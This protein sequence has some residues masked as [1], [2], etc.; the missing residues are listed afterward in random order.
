MP[1]AQRPLAGKPVSPNRGAPPIVV[2]P[3]WLIKALALCLVTALICAYAAACLLYY[4]GEWQFLLHPS[5]TVERTP[6]SVGLLYKDIRFDASETGQPRLTAWWLPADF[7]NQSDANFSAFTVLYLHDGSGSL[8]DTVPTLATLHRV[9]LNVFAIDYRG[10]G[11]S[12]S[13]AHPSDARMTQDAAAAFDYLT[14]VRHIPARNIVP[15]GVGLGASLAARLAHDHPDL[16]AVVLDNP[17]PDPLSAAAGQQ[18][19]IIPLR[20][21][22]GYPFDIARLISILTTPKLLIAGGPNSHG[23]AGGPGRLQDLFRRASGPTLAVTLPRVA[24][25]A[26]CQVALKQFLDQHL[27]N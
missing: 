8:A 9:G 25:E 20:L 24:S 13:S 3:V 22:S 23:A 2:D 17:D 4:Q 26:D 18:S 15:Y 16:P 14:S 12:D 21:L 5:H 11:A 7:P 6:A 27:T 10:F 1:S 19:R